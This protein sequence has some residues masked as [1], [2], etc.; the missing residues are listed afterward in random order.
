M[1][2]VAHRPAGVFAV[3]VGR[4]T[5]VDH[6][7]VRLVLHELL[8]GKVLAEFREVGLAGIADIDRFRRRLE[9]GRIDVAERDQFHVLQPRIL[10][11]V[12]VPDAAEPEDRRFE[13]A[14]HSPFPFR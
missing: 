9:L 14:F 6:V 8:V 12:H 10:R 2:P 5:D 3:Q 4:Q 7:H 1:I 13:F 11:R